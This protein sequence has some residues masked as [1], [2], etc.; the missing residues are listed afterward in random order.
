MIKRTCRYV[1]SYPFGWSP[2]G[3]TRSTFRIPALDRLS[4][5]S[6][7]RTRFDHLTL[8][9]FPIP[10]GF[11]DCNGEEWS[12][13]ITIGAYFNP[14]SRVYSIAAVDIQCRMVGLRLFQSPP[15]FLGLQL[16]SIGGPYPS[17]TCFNPLSGFFGLQRELVYR[18]PWIDRFN[19]LLGFS[20]V[21]TDPTDIPDQRPQALRVSIPSRGFLGLQQV[22]T[23]CL[24]TY[25]VHLTQ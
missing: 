3:L 7:T 22:V 6:L 24:E 19:P 25:R 20:W 13:D 14:P 12:D 4:H 2:G 1:L 23:Y 15:G 5:C 8:L 17:S 16:A 10:L 11:F 9:A 21:A 18:Y